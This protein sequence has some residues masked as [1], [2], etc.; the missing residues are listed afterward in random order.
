MK[1]EETYE[2]TNPQKSIW[3]TEQFYNGFSLNNICGT[4]LI[5]EVTNFNLLKES[6]IAVCKKHDNFKIK[7]IIEND[8]P[9][10]YFDNIEN[11]D[12]DIIN[13]KNKNELEKYRTNIINTPFCITNNF[14]FKIVIFKFPNNY[15]AFTINIHHLIADGWTLGL[16][17]TEVI[18]IYNSLKNN[19]P[20]E[21]DSIS[22]TEYINSEE[23][24]LKSNQFI[25]DKEYWETLISDKPEVAVLPSTI[26]ENSMEISCI[27][28]RKQYEFSAEKIS[29]IHNFCRERN[30]SLYNFF[31]AIYSI[32]IGKITNLNKFIIGTPI[33]N[34]TKYTEKNCFGMFINTA[35]LMVN[36]N[37]NNRFN[38]FLTD[39]ATN[40]LNMLRH[41]KYPYQY[42]I[43]H[44]RKKYNNVPNLYTILLSYQITKAHTEKTNINYTTEWTFNGNCADDLNIHIFDINDAGKLTIAY[45]YK[46]TVFTEDDINLMHNRILNIINQVLNDEN[47]LLKNISIITPNE[48]RELLYNFNNTKL[49]YNKHIPIIRY[50]EKQVEQHPNNIALVFENQT[51]TYKTLNEK[52]N[53]LAY[54][55]REKGIKN[56]SIVGIMENRSFEMIIGILAILKSGGCYI[57]I[58]PE[59]P[60]NRVDYIIENSSLSLILTEKNL[61]EKFSLTVQTIDITLSNNNIYNF[62]KENLCNISTPNDLAY[63]IYTSGSTGTPKGVML[64]QNNL[65]NFYNS[66][67]NTI[68]YLKDNKHHKIISITTVSF[69]IFIFETLISLTRG[70]ELYITN[71]YEQKMTSKL[72]RLI[73]DNKI[74]IIQS[75]P[76]VMK[77]H[78]DNLTNASNFSSL[79]YVMLAGEQLPKLLVDSIKKI[80]PNCTI[81]NGYGPSETTIF[82]TVQN[83]TKLEKINIG[84]PI[85]NTQI[86]ILDKNNSLMP[87][88]TIGE[89]CISGDGVGKGYLNRPDLSK[90]QYIENP[91]FANS[92]IYKTGDLGMWKNNGT[93]E[94]KGRIDNQIKLHGLRIEL[95]EIETKINSFTT[96]NLLHSAVIVKNINGQD[97][98]YAFLSYPNKIDLSTLKKY[99]FTQLPNYMIP[100]TFTQIDELPL[101]PNGKLDRKTL[102]NYKINLCNDNAIIAPPRNE[103]EKILVDIIS[104]KLNVKNFGIDSDIFD[105]GADSLLIINILTELFKYDFNFKVNDFYTYHT[106]RELCD[107]LILK[108][109]SN[110]TINVDKYI[111]LNNIVSNFSKN[112]LATK[113]TTKL[114]IL[115]TGANGFLGAHILA[116]LLNTPINISKIFCIVRNKNKSNGKDR[117]LHIM[118]FYFNKKYDELIEK[119]VQIIEAELSIVNFGLDENIYKN[120][121]QSIDTVIHCAANVKH[122]GKYSNFE[123]INVIGTKNIIDFCKESNSHLHYISTMTISGNYLL[124]QK[125]NSVIFDENSFYK[126]QNFDNNVYSK[127]KLIAESYILEG[128]SNGLTATIYRI[129]D[130]T[131][132][133]SDGV[134]QDNISENSI[135]L[136]LRSI[137]EI[138][139][140]PNSIENNDLEFTPV[141]YA[142]KA[143]KY[144]IYSNENK[145]RIFNIYNPNFICT[146]D[147]LNFIKLSNYNIK[148]IP[149]NKF[150]EL[151]KQLSE[152]INNQSKISGIIND[153][154]ENNELVYNYTIKQNND[155]TCDYLK[156]LGFE[157]PILNSAYINKLIEYMK[158]VNFI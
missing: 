73:H 100:T 44:L 120:L 69:D 66:M 34:R 64:T 26:E 84:K 101:T 115:L 96:D 112:T 29:I 60:K 88:N 35:P 65:T 15:S 77:F 52:A 144:I 79:K 141:D 81:Y 89:I 31:I 71:Y 33:L 153:F 90:K 92:I 40:S 154:T 121:T 86:Y 110:N 51:M 36:L 116:E 4:A 143:L 50:F 61:T 48:K 155:I 63:I 137:L 43:E 23:N 68:K 85:G 74:E 32:Y 70:L 139:S 135:Y 28:H 56:N 131:G 45:D 128:I 133:F 108:E 94:C 147:L 145:N 114:N 55:L 102:Q 19:L 20:I 107:N 58:D 132:R 83:V 8:T 149:Q 97:N 3:L 136:R 117:L 41:Q 49:K 14:L 152:T 46:T 105:F 106:V 87:K 39:V 54:T 47:I 78:I 140:I 142:A 157:W 76:T 95:Q 7:F 6:I 11:I 98:L 138:G 113:K 18:N 146:K 91:F 57:P 25:R 126:M 151:I 37:D 127:S 93:I 5:K 27:A 21:T 123:R 122:Y 67:V 24:Y 150:V 13:V 42:I 109:E 72:E 103:K 9:K 119:Y 17:S 129:G 2:L 38:Q 158:K 22:Y 59:Y 80:S 125:N 148:I 1:K 30:I 156:N 53:S 124:E 75:T 130:L 104:K 99:L 16:F 62:N 118:H 10:Q 111:A 12:I 134:F 82:S